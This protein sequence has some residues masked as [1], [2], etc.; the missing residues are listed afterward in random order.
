M[1]NAPHYERTGEFVNRNTHTTFKAADGALGRHD[2]TTRSTVSGRV[3]LIC[4]IV[5]P[6]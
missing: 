5:Y 1:S 2:L 4:G 6:R 3:N